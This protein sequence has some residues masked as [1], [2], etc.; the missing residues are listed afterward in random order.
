MYINTINA[1][2]ATAAMATMATVDAATITR[3]FYPVLCAQKPRRRLE[4]R[5]LGEFQC[6]PSEDREVRVE[7]DA[8]DPADAGIASP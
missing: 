7:A 6:E 8:L 2:M 4:L 5:V 3:T 1:T